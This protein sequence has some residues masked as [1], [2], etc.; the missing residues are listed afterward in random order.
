MG[1]R[2]PFWSLFAESF[3]VEI[4]LVYRK[5]PW[6]SNFFSR[7]QP[8]LRKISLTV[9]KFFHQGKFPW[10]WKS[11]L[12]EDNF[13]DWGKHTFLTAEKAK[14]LLILKVNASAETIKT[15]L[16]IIEQKRSS[17]LYSVEDFNTSI[18]P[19]MCDNNNKSLLIL[20][21]IYSQKFQLY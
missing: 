19:L 7:K 18:S 13:L 2:D 11:S 8:C 21:Q 12:I 4:F 14:G 10:L 17:V 15:Y 16:L 20:N 3:F 1:F 6:P 9:E 5:F